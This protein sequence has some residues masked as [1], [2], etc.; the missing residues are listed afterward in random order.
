M[1]A[2]LVTM[3]SS[4][5]KWPEVILYRLIGLIRSGHWEFGAFVTDD[6]W[7]TEGVNDRVQLARMNAEVNRLLQ[8][9]EVR[10]AISAQGGEP[11]PLTPEQL[12]ERLAQDAKKWRAAIAATGLTLELG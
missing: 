10:G 5:G 2:S 3:P 4:P 11:R 12:G 7:Q 9:D 1:T 6:L 8:T